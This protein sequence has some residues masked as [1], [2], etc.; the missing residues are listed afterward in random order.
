MWCLT[1]KTWGL[2]VF[3]AEVQQ[4]LHPWLVTQDGIVFATCDHD[5]GGRSEWSRGEKWLQHWNTLLC[6]AEAEGHSSTIY[7]L[8]SRPEREEPS[9]RRKMMFSVY[10]GLYR[11]ASSFPLGCY[12]LE[13]P[14]PIIC[15]ES[16]LRSQQLTPR[17]LFTASMN[18]LS[19]PPPDLLPARSNPGIL[20]PIHSLSLLW[21]VSC[22]SDVL[23][24]WFCPSWSLPKVE[25]YLSGCGSCLC[26]SL[27]VSK[28]DNIAA[29]RSV[30]P[31]LLL[32]SAYSNLLA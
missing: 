28:S 5:N 22:P 19:A 7:T 18:L 3:S 20:P 10:L 6:T 31:V 32:F 16:P 15:C 9:L 24:S 8:C 26:L 23:T 14:R 21:A 1:C 25:L 12:P 30:K 13:S 17:P 27:I 29:L 2:G 4:P 11:P